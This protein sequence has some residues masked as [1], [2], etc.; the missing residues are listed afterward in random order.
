[1]IKRTEVSGQSINEKFQLNQKHV[2]ASL[3]ESFSKMLGTSQEMQDL[4][5]EK[6]FI[7]PHL[8]KWYYLIL[9]VYNFNK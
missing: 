2:L 5:N 8:Q 9:K 3:N 7:S 4:I 6:W 1:M